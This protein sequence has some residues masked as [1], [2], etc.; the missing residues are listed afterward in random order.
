MAIVFTPFSA[1]NNLVEKILKDINDK[2]SLLICLRRFIK[3]E[4]A[5]VRLLYPSLI[6]N[7]V[8]HLIVE[9]LTAGSC[10]LVIIKGDNLFLKIKDI[11]G[12]FHCEHNQVVASGLRLKYQKD[13]SS[14]EFI[15]HTTDSSHE[16]EE[17]VRR[18]F[19]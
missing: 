9:C 4:V 1:Q 6:A 8:F 5:E 16:A 11:K 18:F 10:E 2:V 7:P 13:E 19:Y 3:L 14:F 12:K 15:F 17:I